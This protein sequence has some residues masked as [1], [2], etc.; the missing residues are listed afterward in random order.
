VYGY[1]GRK[2]F[3]V[4]PVS[5]TATLIA[6]ANGRRASLRIQNTG[7]VPVYLGG[8]DTVTPLT[9]YRLAAGAEV[10]DGESKDAWYGIVPAGTSEVRICEVSI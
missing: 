2:T 6:A 7:T 5:T 4:V 1:G 10:L 3:A 8:D 9:G